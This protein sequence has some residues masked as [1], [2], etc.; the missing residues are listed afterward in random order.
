[1]TGTTES[2]Q[3]VTLRLVVAAVAR[4]F[5]NTA[6]RMGF[7]FAPALGRGLEVPLT[8]ITSLLAAQ[9]F[10]GLFGVISGPLSDRAGR[11]KMML[12]GSAMLAMGMLVGGVTGVFWSVLLALFLAGLGKVFFDPAVLSYIG[13]WV[14]YEKRGRAIG[15]SEFA[16]AGSMLIGMPLV[17]VLISQV[18]WRAPFFLFGCAGLVIGASVF[19]LFPRDSLERHTTNVAADLWRSWRRVVRK[20]VAL[21]VLSFSL[22][23]SVANQVLFVIYGVWME[24]S[25]GLSIVALGSVT[26]LIGVAELLGEGLTAWI[27]DRVGLMRA[28]LVGAVVLALSYLLL[29]VLEGSLVGAL[30]GLFVV[31][32]SFEFTIVTTMS[33]MTEVVP[34]AR[35]TVV[36]GN[37]VA[38]SLGRVAGVAIGGLV[39]LAGGL[40]ANCLLAAAVTGVAVASLAWG[41]RGVHLAAQ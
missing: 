30:V 12:A 24:D 40:A 18:G 27:A 34:G 26:I 6:L 25:Y 21:F 13:E 36:S 1:M 9:Q 15:L 2:P 35:A 19:L 16:W 41:L 37:Q 33:L 7:P 11:R 4:L 29:P 32:L 5:F 39:W 28:V 23:I 31:F 8:S 14:P 10:T 20:P 17:A 3:G 22:L 38:T